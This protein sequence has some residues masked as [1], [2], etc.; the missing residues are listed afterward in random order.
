MRNCH[1]SRRFICHG[2]GA[3]S[4]FELNELNR[5]EATSFPT[6][7]DG[8]VGR[9]HH[10]IRTMQQQFTSALDGLTQQNS[11]LQAEVAQS[12]QQAANELAALRQ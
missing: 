8:D 5:V 2:S 9:S 1:S 11:E 10:A 12:R 4:V 7:L 3:D 6:P